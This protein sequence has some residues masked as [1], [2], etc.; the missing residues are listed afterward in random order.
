MGKVKKCLQKS[1]EPNLCEE[2]YL[3]KPKW[4]CDDN[5]KQGLAKLNFGNVKW[6]ETLQPNIQ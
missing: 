4:S 2:G 1:E 3:E 6:I 5:I